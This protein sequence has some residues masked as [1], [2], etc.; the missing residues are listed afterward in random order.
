MEKRFSTI[1][2]LALF[3]L[4]GSRSH[5]ADIFFD[6]FNGST[7]NSKAWLFAEKAWG[8]GGNNGG[9]VHDNVSVTNGCLRLEAHGDAYTGTVQGVD[10][11][12]QRAARVTRVGGAIATTN[13]FASGRYEVR[14]Q[15][16]QHY[17]AVSAIWTFH[18]E[19]A[20]AGTPLYDVLAALGGVSKTD[21]LNLG[22]TQAEVDSLWSDMV[23]NKAA[24][25]PYLASITAST[26]T[27]SEFFRAHVWDVTKL[28][29]VNDFGQLNNI[30]ILLHDGLGLGVE[31]SAYDGYYIVRNHE[32]DIE[33]P[34]A[35][36]ATPDV[37]SYRN[38]RL[39]TWVGE[40]GGNFTD[41]FDDLGAVMNDGQFHTFR[42]D[43]HTGDSNQVKRVEFYIDDV[44]KQTNYTDVPTI[45]GR[46]WLGLWFPSWAGNPAFDVDG[47]L[48][49]WV[50]IAPFHESGDQTVPETYPND[51]WWHPTAM[52]L[53]LSAPSGGGNVRI[54]ATLSQPVTNLVDI[55]ESTNVLAVNGW[56]LCASNLPTGGSNQVFWTD[57]R[58]LQG[59]RF[60]KANLKQ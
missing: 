21:F 49:D 8:A 37:I 14:M 29:L 60:Y 41:P 11:Y 59:A 53:G 42:F 45:A 30:Y 31:G 47:L 4:A 25:G 48:I 10:N 36:A 54:T 50:R 35:L 16:P 24:R 7:L 58:P 12:G 38:A 55:Y 44:P 22:L 33:T 15:L 18:Y 2:L 39:N 27:V 32:I 5:A 3:V 28:D 52:S 17:G 46:F 51:G 34:T 6:D 56:S 57:P 20:Y 9:V 40:T 13:Y 23:T 19:E 43:W 26:A 1:L